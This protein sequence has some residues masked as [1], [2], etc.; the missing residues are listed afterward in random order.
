MSDVRPHLA[1][2]LLLPATILLLCASVLRAPPAPYSVRAFD[3][4]VQRGIDL[5]YNLQFEPADSYF[6]EIVAA[7]PANPLGYFFLAMVTWWRVLIDLE[8]RSHDERFYELLSRCIEVCDQRLETAPDDFDAILFKAGAIGFRGRLRGNR[9]QYLRAA[10]DG[11]KCMPLLK[12]SG[13]LE[14]ENKDILFGRGVYNYFIEVIPKNYPVVRP[15]TWLLPG[16]KRETGLE[17]LRLVAAEGQYAAT[18]ALY[19][20][21]Q[22]HRL[23]ERDKAASLQYLEHL[24][25]RYPQNS[26]FHRFTART[27]VE[28]GQWNRGTALFEQ[29]LARADAKQTGY[30][31]FGQVEALYYLGQHAWL[32]QRYG[33]ALPLLERAERL[34]AGQSR[35]S[36][37]KYR[38]LCL[39]LLGKTHDLRGDREQALDHYQQ[40]R[41]LPN[42]GTSHKQAQTYTKTAFREFR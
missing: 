30:H 40:V 26:I 25:R 2:R 15:I 12:T 37:D 24:H 14:P 36:M 8:D 6:E 35:A 17:Q 29:V 21:A 32:Q 7:D 10:S 23:F 3:P 18:E 13:E 41:A 31:V 34:A 5:I 28:L 33:E 22:I 42:Y 16:G 38:T 11:L 39:L 9:G 1:R 4:R 20:L 19:F 27:L